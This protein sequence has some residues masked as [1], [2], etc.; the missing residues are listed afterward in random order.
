MRETSNRR[1]KS[2]AFTSSKQPPDNLIW[3]LS[4]AHSGITELRA[5]NEA[6]KQARYQEDN[7]DQ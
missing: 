7:K 6:E 3:S 4:W 5:M 2:I 1:E